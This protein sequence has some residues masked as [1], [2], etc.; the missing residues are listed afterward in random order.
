MAQA[1]SELDCPRC[2]IRLLRERSS[3]GVFWKCE[4]CAG[5]AVGVELLRRTFTPASINPLWLHTI[6][7]QGHASFGCPSC[8]NAMTEV[9]VSPGSAVRVDVCRLCHFVWFDACEV[10]TL[11]PRPLPESP[12]PVP[13]KAREMAAIARV[14]QLA[15]EAKIR[16]FADGL[17]WEFWEVIA[18]FLGMGLWK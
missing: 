11:T 13:Q 3:Y 4:R 12:P 2:E 17:S 6:Q 5:R 9:A 8:K 18:R 1:A 10:D 16:D 15:A 14:Q 7:G